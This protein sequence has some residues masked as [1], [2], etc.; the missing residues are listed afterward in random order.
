MKHRR[1]HFTRLSHFT[2]EPL[3]ES[4]NAPSNCC[5]LATLSCPARIT[6][7]LTPILPVP[8]VATL[9]GAGMIGPFVSWQLRVPQYNQGPR[10]LH[11]AN[12][13]KFSRASRLSRLFYGPRQG[14]VSI[15]SATCHDAFQPSDQRHI[16]RLSVPCSSRS[17]F[18][19]TTALVRPRALYFR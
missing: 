5:R 13:Y 1:F 15:P 16:H 19:L 7:D 2:A 12:S 8:G 11:S 14:S 4:W 6:I 9:I 18:S 3:V 10:L 17:W